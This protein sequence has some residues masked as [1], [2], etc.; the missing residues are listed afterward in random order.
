[1][2][3]VSQDHAPIK[4]AMG[5]DLLRVS[6]QIEAKLELSVDFRVS[7]FE[8]SDHQPVFVLE[9]YKPLTQR[10]VYLG[11]V[12]C[13]TRNDQ[14]GIEV[15]AQAEDSPRPMRFPLVSIL[16]SDLTPDK[17]LQVMNAAV[18][19]VLVYS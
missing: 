8:E 10:G 4:S 5:Y 11:E 15:C 1:M 3:A 12:C 13:R 6:S 9:L 2:L 18:L 16:Q 19:L 17:L 7:T 14:L